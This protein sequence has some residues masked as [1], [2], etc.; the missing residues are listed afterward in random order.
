M[1]DV[2]EYLVNYGRSGFLG[3][4]RASAEV[5]CLRGDRVV[6]R[7]PRGIELGTVLSEADARLKSLATAEPPGVLLRTATHTDEE[8][9][10]CL[11]QTVEK[12]LSDAQ[13][14]AAE[15]ELPLT[16]LDIEVPLDGE[17]A[18]LHAVH[19]AECDATPLLDELSHAHGTA[20][21]L[22]DQT[23][24][25]QSS[26]AEPNGCGKPDCGSGKGGCDSCST[27]GGCSTGSCSR[28][29]VKSAEELTAYFASL[30]AQMEAQH[31]RVALH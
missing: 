4:F 31:A 14:L 28:G 30:R 13:R 21:R 1:V 27:G 22:L 12:I 29:S 19:W 3:V 17:T 9:A 24:S 18:V 20:V 6:I 2:R 25:P 23:R 7:S 16:F 5:E 10:S 8:A 11:Q 26:I 15:R